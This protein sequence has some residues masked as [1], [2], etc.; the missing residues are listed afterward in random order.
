MAAVEAGPRPGAPTA[1]HLG[2]FPGLADDVVEQSRTGIAVAEPDG[3]WVWANATMRGILTAEGVLLDELDAAIQALLPRARERALEVMASGHSLTERRPGGPGASDLQV[4]YRPWRDRSGTIAGAL[5]FMQDPG[6]IAEATR[7]WGETE[8]KYRLLA[9]QATDVVALID[10]NGIVRYVSPSVRNVLGYE[11]D[12]LVGRPQDVIAHPDDVED[13]VALATRLRTGEVVTICTR[14]RRADG[15]WAWVE[16][17]ARRMTPTADDI[18]AQVAS[19]DVSERIRA[20]VLAQ[21]GSSIDRVLLESAD[22]TA[23]LEVACDALSEL[24]ECGLVAV[25][26]CGPSGDLQ[27]AAAAGP[28]AGRARLA[29]GTSDDPLLPTLLDGFH[30]Q[31]TA[32]VDPA[33]G[34]P[35]GATAVSVPIRDGRDSVVALLSFRAIDRVRLDDE[36]VGRLEDV[37]DR[38]AVA[39]RVI[40]DR[41]ELEAQRLALVDANQRLE[42][43]VQARTAELGAALEELESFTFS[44][45]HDL[46]APLRAIASYAEL[47]AEDQGDRLDPRGLADIGLIHDAATRLSELVDALLE[48]SRVTR[49]D[50]DRV[51]VDLAAQAEEIAVG[52]WREQPDRRVELRVHQPVPPAVADPRLTRVLLSN[53]LGN[54]WKFTATRP[55]GVVEL[56]SDQVGDQTVYWVQ[57][58]GVGFEPA[59][60]QRLFI[61]FQRL[62]PAEQF[63]GTGVGLATVARIARRH[64]GR[65]W[66]DATPGH[67]A[68]FSFTLAPPTTAVARDGASA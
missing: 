19:R 18:V 53:L 34:D 41:A 5:L 59:H 50:L 31:R 35:H 15:R 30:L 23:C 12:E 58:N 45:S 32:R 67:G 65:V 21:A 4:R 39:R 61:A 7:R 54:A 60:A 47:L 43:R 44:V 25:H 27:V 11:P 6:P 17:V 38:L 8:R 64:G 62:H 52:L 16:S 33:P 14:V 28:L 36:S 46:R 66:G 37:A 10:R 3:R 57:D 55:V 56:G 22:W 29:R 24:L 48:L 2:E 40:D 51:P 1:R 26:V 20:T 9:E 42:E 68:R 13:P 63:P 49:S